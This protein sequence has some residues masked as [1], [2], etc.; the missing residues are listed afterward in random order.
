M[1]VTERL[2]RRQNE[3]KAMMGKTCNHRLCEVFFDTH[4]RQSRTQRATRLPSQRG[5]QRVILS[6]EAH[7][8]PPVPRRINQAHP[9]RDLIPTFYTVCT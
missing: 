2:N 4:Y 3:K 7:V 6:C 1:S 5:T 8:L 9:Y